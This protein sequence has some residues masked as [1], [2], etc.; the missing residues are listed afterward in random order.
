VKSH[1]VDRARHLVLRAGDGDTLPDD[2]LRALG[3][4]GV[5]SGWFRGNGVL[6]DV[7]LRVFDPATGG[8]AA[9]RRI[10]GPLQALSIEGSIGPN[11]T[12]ASLGLHAVLARETDRGMETLAGEIVWARVVAL[13]AFVTA[14]D[15]LSIG[16]AVDEK[17]RVLLFSAAA[18]S[19]TEPRPRAAGDAAPVALPLPPVRAAIAAPPPPAPPSA[20]AL[21]TAGWSDAIAASTEQEQARQPVNRGALGGAIPARPVR[22]QATIDE[23]MIP[24]AGDIVEHFAFGRAEV[25]KSDGDRLHLRVGG[26]D[27]RIREIALEM[28]KVSPLSSDG[29]H[30][31]WRL[32]RKM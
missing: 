14:F 5:T 11:G 28:L 3:D 27:G 32:D 13:E 15:D 2:A 4:Q 25:V 31:R 21:P 26:K 1:S 20:P 9:P 8:L 6:V 7:A 12:E 30:R 22:P 16:R 19:G 24:E 23:A 17:A 18:E 10:A 29:P